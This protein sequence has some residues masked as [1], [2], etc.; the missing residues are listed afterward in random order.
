LPHVFAMT[1]VYFPFSRLSLSP[2]FSREPL[3]EVPFSSSSTWFFIFLSLL[4]WWREGVVSH[5][6]GIPLPHFT[7]LALVVLLFLTSYD[8]ASCFFSFF[9]PNRPPPLAPTVPSDINYF[10]SIFCRCGQRPR[11]TQSP[12]APAHRSSRS[13]PA[14]ICLES[15]RPIS[16]TFPQSFCFFSLSYVVV[17]LRIPIFIFVYRSSDL[18]FAFPRRFPTS[19]GVGSVDSPNK[20]FVFA[21]FRSSRFFA[22]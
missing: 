8:D 9:P 19:S 11:R 5:F 2:S 7:F 1:V 3:Q 16:T 12:I 10:P 4:P 22:P 20:N 15:A 14:W 6:F 21:C 13:L 17:K 18:L